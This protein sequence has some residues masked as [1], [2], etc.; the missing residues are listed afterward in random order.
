M[1]NIHN[2]KGLVSFNLSRNPEDQKEDL[3]S[4]RGYKRTAAIT[5]L[6]Q[7]ATQHQGVNISVV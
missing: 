1:V 4:D 5:I 6:A 3:L 7:S 2:A